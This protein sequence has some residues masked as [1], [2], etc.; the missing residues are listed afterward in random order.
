MERIWNVSVVAQEIDSQIKGA[1]PNPKLLQRFYRDGKKH[2]K[3]NISSSPMYEFIK[4]VVEIATSKISEDYLAEQQQNQNQL[5]GMKKRLSRLE[6]PDHGGTGVLGS[7]A[8]NGPAE[9]IAVSDTE[10]ATET[11]P[12]PVAGSD[13]SSELARLKA[14]RAQSAARQREEQARSELE[15]KRSEIHELSQQIATIEQD[16][17]GSLSRYRQLLESCQQTGELF[18]SRYRQGYSEK[19][20]PG[21]ELL[22]DIEFDYPVVLL[23]AYQ[24]APTQLGSIEES[25]GE[26]NGNV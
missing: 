9:G 5:A 1:R 20:P 25:E 6:G 10:A 11:D 2:G 24:L 21:D 23:Q 15:Q 12:Q 3:K 17:E 26:P 16:L 7:D 8:G 18:W 19:A 14:T 22:A 4:N 13:M